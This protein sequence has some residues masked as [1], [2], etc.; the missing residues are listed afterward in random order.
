[1][2]Q[3]S[4]LG[5]ALNTWRPPGTRVSQGPAPIHSVSGYAICIYTGR[6]VR[7]LLPDVGFRE[8]VF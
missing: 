7:R 2:S 5:P 1:M 3:V 8:R 4:R 6:V